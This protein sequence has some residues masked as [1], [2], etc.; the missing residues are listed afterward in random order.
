MGCLDAYIRRFYYVVS[1]C[2]VGCAD[3]FKLG[4]DACDQNAYTKAFKGIVLGAQKG[5]VFA[6]YEVAK[7]GSGISKN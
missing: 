1:D 5:L 4:L 3:E 2:I 6:Q 7:T